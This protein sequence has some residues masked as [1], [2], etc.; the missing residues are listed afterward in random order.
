MTDVTFLGPLT[1]KKGAHTRGAG[2]CA[3]EAAAYLASEPH[4]D[5]PV[6]VSPVIAAFMRRWN[7]RLPDAERQRLKPL[8]P[9]VLHT[10][11]GLDDDK[12][13]AWLCADWA[14]RERLPMWLER[15]PK[16]AT[17]AVQLR[18]L[19]PLVDKASADKAKAVI[20]G[21]R[22][23]ADDAAYADAAYAAAAAAYA[24]AADAAYAAADAADAPFRETLFQSAYGLV[25]RLIAVGTQ[26]EP[27]RSQET[28]GVGTT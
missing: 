5:S 20:Q 14:V 25:L 4:S 27:L 2:M 1:L 15:V 26:Q 8:I 7:D 13:R 18:A 22:S 16:L 23:T 9:L 12:T 28:A 3:M 17:W 21:A 6:C 19:P 11:T 10:A 24:A